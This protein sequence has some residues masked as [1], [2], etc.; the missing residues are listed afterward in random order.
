MTIA[1]PRA[2]STT[3]RRQTGYYN[4]I[5]FVLSM[6]HPDHH[7]NG[8]ET[9]QLHAARGIRHVAQDKLMPANSIIFRRWITLSP[10]CCISPESGRCASARQVR[11]PPDRSRLCIHNESRQRK[12]RTCQQTCSLPIAEGRV[13]ALFRCTLNPVVLPSRNFETS[14][15][16]QH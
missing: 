12:P 6:V 10:D 2:V 9:Q 16:T 15:P 4:E 11:F 5:L 13:A 1:R 7:P 14:F 8:F 3:Q